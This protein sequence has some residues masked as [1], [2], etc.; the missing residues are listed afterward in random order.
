MFRPKRLGCRVARTPYE[1]LRP[2]LLCRQ[3]S[4]H[5]S[6]LESWFAAQRQRWL[7]ILSKVL[8]LPEYEECE[9]RSYKNRNY[10]P[11]LNNMGKTMSR[12][13]AALWYDLFLIFV[14][15]GFGTFGAQR[16]YGRIAP[17]QWTQGEQGA[18]AIVLWLSSTSAPY[19]I[20]LY[21]SFLLTARCFQNAR[22]VGLLNR[23]VSAVLF[24]ITH[25]SDTLLCNLLLEISMLFE[26]RRGVRWVGQFIL[27][28]R[29][30]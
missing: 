19:G 7:F 22:N 13:I 12:A 8:A 29:I 9:G 1:I 5:W 4:S 30:I 28:C 18:H 20:V 10:D 2:V 17:E 21:L 16:M 6:E 24:S 27:S 15:R 25:W 26:A 3:G 23:L 11:N 14:I